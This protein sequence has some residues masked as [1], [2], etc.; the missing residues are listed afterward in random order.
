MNWS[1]FTNPT[2]EPVDPELA[3]EIIDER[4]DRL[5]DD[6][7]NREIEAKI[8]CNHFWSIPDDKRTPFILV[9]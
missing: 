3:Q 9:Q 2:N 1:R 8:V 7:V 6:D 4:A 5:R